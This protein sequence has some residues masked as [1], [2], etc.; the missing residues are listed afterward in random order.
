MIG[1]AEMISALGFLFGPILGSILYSIGGYT[2][3]FIVIGSLALII[4]PIIGF[5]FNKKKNNEKI[6]DES[7]QKMIV[8]DSILVNIF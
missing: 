6:A 4:V 2:L 8:N 5:Q 7:I 3:P 1:I